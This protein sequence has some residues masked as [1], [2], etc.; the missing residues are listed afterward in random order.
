[1]VFRPFSPVLSIETW[2]EVRMALQIRLN[3]RREQ[4]LEREGFVIAMQAPLVGGD[5]PDRLLTS[6]RQ[7]TRRLLR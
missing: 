7:R 4:A 5:F 6:A 1:M 3:C 2:D